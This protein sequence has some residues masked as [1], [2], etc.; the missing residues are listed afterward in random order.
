[1]MIIRILCGECIQPLQECMVAAG[2]GCV[3]LFYPTVLL[4]NF[5][6]K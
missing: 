3:L 5:L 4:G 6:V 2:G 1:M